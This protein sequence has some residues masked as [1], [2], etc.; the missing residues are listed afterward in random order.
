MDQPG[1]ATCAG[2]DA[3]VWTGDGSIGRMRVLMLSWEYPPVVVGGLCRH[4][5]ALAEAMAAAGDEVAVRTRHPAT[6]DGPH[7]EVVDSVRVIRAAEDP[8]KLS[9]ADDPLAWTTTLNHAPTRA[10]LAICAERSFDVVHAHDR[11]VAH[12]ATTLEHHL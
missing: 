3:S 2:F 8:T 11:L 12:A 4:V 1:R 6:P 5:P 7:D 9:F 10:G